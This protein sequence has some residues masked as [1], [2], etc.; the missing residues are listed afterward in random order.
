MSEPRRDH[1]VAP[2]T[3]ADTQAALD[4]AVKLLSADRDLDTPDPAATVHLVASLIAEAQARLP[5]AV[6]QARD[7]GCSW[8]EIADLLGVTRASAWQR[9]AS[10]E[11]SPG[12]ARSNRAANRG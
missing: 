1:Y 10:P 9:Y 4:A 5:R 7:Y 2:A 3:G 12:P 8:A 6:R 11:L